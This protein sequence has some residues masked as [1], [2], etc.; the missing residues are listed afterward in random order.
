[1]SVRPNKKSLLLS[2]KYSDNKA[3]LFENE[4]QNNSED[5]RSNTPQF[6]LLV[7]LQKQSYDASSN[8]NVKVTLKTKNFKF[9]IQRT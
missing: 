1:M 2:L 6:P 8:F 7:A 3:N 9:E 5:S 4:N